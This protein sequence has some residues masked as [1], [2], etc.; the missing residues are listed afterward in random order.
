MASYEADEV[1]YRV[2]QKLYI[3]ISRLMKMAGIEQK[4]H[5]GKVGIFGYRN[6]F[7]N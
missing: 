5:C 4:L 6:I 7:R 1:R 2:S 3:K